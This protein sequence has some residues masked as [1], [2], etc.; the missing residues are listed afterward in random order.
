M[1]SEQLYTAAQMA[2]FVD[3]DPK[4]AAL[5]EEMA[6]AAERREQGLPPAGEAENGLQEPSEA[7]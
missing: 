4:R 7:N 3:H 2:A 6:R 5:F 1:T